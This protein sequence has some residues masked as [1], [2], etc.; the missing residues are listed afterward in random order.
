MEKADSG[1]LV[2]PWPV[3]RIPSFASRLGRSLNK[4]LVLQRLAG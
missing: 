4:A 1:Y 3:V 2:A